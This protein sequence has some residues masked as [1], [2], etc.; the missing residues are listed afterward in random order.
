MAVHTY[1]DRIKLGTLAFEARFKDGY[2]YLDRCGEAIVQ[3]QSHNPFWLPQGANP[4]AGNL[5]NEDLNM[6]LSLNIIGLSMNLS[7]SPVDP[8]GTTVERYAGEAEALYEIVI[9]A[10]GVTQ[11]TRVGARFRFLAEADTLEEADRFVCNGAR[12]PLVDHIEQCTNS[13]LIDAGVAY[14]VE[15]P[16]S[17]Y[18]RRVEVVS[19]VPQKAGEP[20][21]TGLDR[22][23]RTG[24][25][26]IDI[27]T[28]TRPGRGHFERASLFIQD[29]FSRSQSICRE[30]FEWLR[31]RQPAKSR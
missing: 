13:R 19:H 2:R 4:M 24:A 5:R 10:L 22:E 27:D 15:D 16:E 7:K 26:A 14:L 9:K 30:T 12:S 6:I 20:P 29:C 21:F 17:G 25:V 28:F 1:V 31:Q 18:R 11:T 3:I 23:G 8:D